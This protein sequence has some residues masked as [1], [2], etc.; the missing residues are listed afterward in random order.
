[1]S[2]LLQVLPNAKFSLK[3]HPRHGLPTPPAE[4]E[5]SEYRI[6]LV[7]TTTT[8]EKKR[9]LTA[10][11]ELKQKR[12]RVFA[13]AAEEVNARDPTRSD[14]AA[15]IK[16]AQSELARL[17]VSDDLLETVMSPAVETVVSPA[18]ET[19]AVNALGERPQDIDSSEDESW[20]RWTPEDIPKRQMPQKG[21][22]EPANKEVAN[23]EGVWKPA[24][25]PNIPL[26]QG[27]SK[28]GAAG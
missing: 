6:S 11:T 5:Y 12:L 19:V 14:K 17:I 21:K 2:L 24:E 23:Y 7:E 13:Q 22:A 27:G 9:L 10:A 16:R 26:P 25:E 8:E 20:G 4:A 28:M 18:V 1:M 15:S 3:A